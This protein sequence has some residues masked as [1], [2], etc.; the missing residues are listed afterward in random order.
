MTDELEFFDR[1]LKHWRAGSEYEMQSNE[2]RLEDGRIAG[3]IRHRLAERPVGRPKQS[4]QR[5]LTVNR[6]IIYDY[7]E[8]LGESRKYIKRAVM[9]EMMGWSA[10]KAREFDRTYDPDSPRWRGRLNWMLG[11]GWTGLSEARIHCA[12]MRVLERLNGNN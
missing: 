11:R 4:G 1:L 3:Q 12:Y 7:L 8:N 5:I 6:V 9:A 10:S 2:A